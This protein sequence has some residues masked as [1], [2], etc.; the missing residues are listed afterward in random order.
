MKR[1]VL[2]AFALSFA[3]VTMAVAGGAAE[4][5]SSTQKATQASVSASGGIYKIAEYV[6]PAQMSNFNPFLPTGNFTGLF[7]YIYDSLLYFN[8][9]QKKLEPR[10]AISFSW[11][12]ND[13]SL[14]MNLAPNVKWQDGAPFSAKDVVFT[15]DLLKRYPV[16]D[17]YQLWNNLQSIT[18]DG[19]K[20]VFTTKTD[21]PSLP[22]Y[23]STV[24]IVPEHIWKNHDPVTFLNTNP[25]GTGA[26]IFKKYNVGTDIELVANKSY[27]GGAPHI[28]GIDI[29][30]YS[31]ATAVTLALL[32]GDAQQNIAS[33]AVPNIPRLLEKKSEHIQLYPGLTNFVVFLNNANSV[34]ANPVVRR[35][36][37]MA[38]DRTEIIKKADLNADFEMNDA[39][40]PPLFGSLVSKKSF[41][42]ADL[43]YD[44]KAAE[45][46]L[47]DNG[48]TRGADGYFVDPSGKPLSFTYYVA[49]GAPAQ[50]KEADMVAQ[51]LKAV[52]IK[53]TLRLATWPELTSIARSG[54]YE[55]VQL[56]I[57]LPPD[58]YTFLYP[59]FAS[60]ATAPVG[61]NTNGLNYG[62]YRN[63]KVDA[64]LAQLA[65][66]FDAAQRE[67]LFHEIQREIVKSVPPYI[68]MHNSGGH[69]LYNTEKFTGY[70]T[71]YP[72]SS[73]VN[74]LS[75]H[76]R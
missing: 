10:L 68:P 13:R 7:E 45:K 18:A 29:L 49:A 54:N 9:V 15:F 33:I 75:I 36:M 21:F 74:M 31:S 16:L 5:S 71:D 63:P 59:V 34:L 40:L 43:R 22:Y 38:V 24:Y 30:T 69:V 27:F 8:P 6:I 2:L 62:R 3:V 12:S 26:F 73:V 53:V 47:T 58:P 4:K 72:V 41:N 55:M 32:R 52:G 51:M 44:P 50:E 57:T 11:S 70:R 35:A 65:H 48:F 76:L 23:L 64:L 67:T 14:Q 17:T 1:I 19:N 42:A 56:G 37:I 66:T 46:L 60:S 25:I 39:F 28:A 20:V 61:Q